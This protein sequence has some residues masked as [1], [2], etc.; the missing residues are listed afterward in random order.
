MEIKSVENI[1][2]V[3]KDGI[4]FDEI[5]I[6]YINPLTNNDA[7]TSTFSIKGAPDFIVQRDAEHKVYSELELNTKESVNRKIKIIKELSN[8]NDIEFFEVV[9]GY[10][11]YLKENENNHL[12]NISKEIKRMND[13]T[14]SGYP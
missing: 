10:E 12:R 8:E 11:M 2:S 13:T 14:S 4:N 7:F 5:L 9:Q 6:H 1:G 3:T